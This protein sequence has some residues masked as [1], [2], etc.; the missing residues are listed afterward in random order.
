MTA[1]LA[2][3]AITG[4]GSEPSLIRTTK[5]SGLNCPLPEAVLALGGGGAP[6]GVARA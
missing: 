1:E 5:W 2:H 4:M 3:Y 6:Y